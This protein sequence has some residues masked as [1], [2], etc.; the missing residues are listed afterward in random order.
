MFWLGQK[1]WAL[2]HIFVKLSIIFLIRRLLQTIGSWHIITVG[3]VVFTIAWGITTLVG[4]TLQCLPPQYFWV[5]DIDGHCSSNQQAF[6]ICIG[7]LALAEDVVL[8]L[9]PIFMVATLQLAWG[10]K[11]R[12]I[13]L[14][15]LGGL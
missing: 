4:N 3:L 13:A 2:A 8:L 6:S 11:V 10:E 15:S 5:R 7:S 1:F 14:F 9:I 12:I